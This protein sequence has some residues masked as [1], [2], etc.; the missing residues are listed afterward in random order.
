[1]STNVG[2][3]THNFERVCQ[4]NHFDSS[5]HLISLRSETV[6]INII[7]SKMPNTVTVSL[8]K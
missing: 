5:M 3:I 1:M 7:K 4:I 6:A 2:G 8:L